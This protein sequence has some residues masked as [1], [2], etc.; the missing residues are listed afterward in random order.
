MNANLKISGEA[1]KKLG[2]A[3][4][5]TASL[6]I[7][8]PR[9][10]LANMSD[11]KLT[12]SQPFQSPQ[13]AG[14]DQFDLGQKVELWNDE[15]R[16]FSGHFLYSEPD[17]SGD[18]F[19]VNRMVIGPWWWMR[20]TPLTGVVDAEAGTERAT[21]VFPNGDLAGHLLTLLKR[22]IALGVPIQIGE[23]AECYD[24]AQVTLKKKSVG[25]GLSE[26]MSKLPDGVVEIDHSGTGFPTVNIR[27]RDSMEAATFKRGVLPLSD[28]KIRPRIDQQATQVQVTY[29]SR[30]EDGKR[31]IS[32]Q[33][34]GASSGALPSRQIVAVSGDELGQLV[35]D[36][37]DSQE[38]E[39]SGVASDS[40]L[41]AIALARSSEFQTAKENPEGRPRCRPFGHPA[42]KGRQQR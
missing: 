25:D 5:T 18:N 14:V 33:I 13:D 20:Q 16:V 40:T 1:G 2:E 26:L 7:E 19:T 6:G 39:T 8:R 24:I 37:D 22:A 23:I 3:R 38:V 29:L 21:L 31:V 27:R 4:V 30:D 28:V 41:L 12:F 10:R 34:A 9:V 32:E 42:G 11:D 17:D 35:P 36:S 15:K